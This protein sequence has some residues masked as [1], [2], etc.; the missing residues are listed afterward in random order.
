MMNHERREQRLEANW[1]LFR[2][3]SMLAS[4]VLIVLLL[5]IDAQFGFS[6][7]KLNVVIVMLALILFI[8]FRLD[9]WL[10]QLVKRIRERK[11]RNH[12]SL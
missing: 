8:L 12:K 2:K 6:S 7:W 4:A 9:Y 10:H 11:W 1:R 5:A 3:T